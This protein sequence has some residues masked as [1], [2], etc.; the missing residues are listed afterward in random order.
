MKISD[1]LTL[2]IEAILDQPRH[3]QMGGLID[4][5]KGLVEH[6]K[7]PATSHGQE[8]SRQ[9]R[10]TTRPWVRVGGAESEDGLPKLVRD[11]IPEIILRSGR[12]PVYGH[13]DKR[14]FAGWLYKKLHEESREFL[15]DP[16]PAELID[17]LE[18][19]YAIVDMYGIPRKQFEEARLVKA[20]QAG[21]FSNQYVLYGCQEEG[22]SS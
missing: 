5:F 19:V 21:A 11:R 13:V 22:E 15:A 3:E 16:D 9:C 17:V 7:G 2:E 1:E 8:A 4:L 20:T 10:Q 18:V 14:D 6:S 12:T